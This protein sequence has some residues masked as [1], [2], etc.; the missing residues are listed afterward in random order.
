MYRHTHRNNNTHHCFECEQKNNHMHKVASRRQSLPCAYAGT[1]IRFPGT[2]ENRCVTRDYL[3]DVA[4][5]RACCVD[6][7]IA[8]AFQQ[9]GWLFEMKRFGGSDFRACRNTNFRHISRAVRT[10]PLST[11][12]MA[13]APN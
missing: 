3:H 8:F 6:R 7:T 9:A 2:A 10:F 5:A 13:G 1:L 4:A 11:A 12:Q